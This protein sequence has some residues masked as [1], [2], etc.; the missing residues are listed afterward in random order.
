M[1]CAG[2]DQQ[3]RGGRG[4]WEPLPVP[5]SCF[6]ITLNRWYKCY[7]YDT[8]V[9][10]LRQYLYIGR[11]MGSTKSLFEFDVTRPIL[12]SLLPGTISDIHATCNHE[13]SPIIQR[14]TGPRQW[15]LGVTVTVGSK[16]GALWSQWIVLTLTYVAIQSYPWHTFFLPNIF[17]TT[18]THAVIIFNGLIFY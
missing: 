15:L 16:L 1:T 5:A 11:L 7:T 13:A 12:L 3:C 18:M 6:V 10:I 8:D 17:T 2:L 9:L 14:H 4:D